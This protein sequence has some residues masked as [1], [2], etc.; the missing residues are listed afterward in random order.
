MTVQ[1]KMTNEM[2]ES[3]VTCCESLLIQYLP[4]IRHAVDIRDAFFLKHRRR[5]LAFEA[6]QDADAFRA[7]AAAAEDA[8]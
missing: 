4:Y 2:D 1:E 6:G 7:G 5:A 3:P 8:E